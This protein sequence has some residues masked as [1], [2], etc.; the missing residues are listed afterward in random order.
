MINKKIIKLL[1]ENTKKFT[2]PLINLIIEE[3]GKKP[4]LILIACLLSLRAKDTTTIHVCRGL[5]SRALTPEAMFK[6]SHNELEKIIYKSGFYK[7]KASTIHEVS[8]VILEKFD[9]KVPQN[10]DQL[11]SIKGVGA[12]TANLVM[13]MAFGVPA[14]CVDTHV[15]RISNRLGIIKTE[16]PEQTQVELEKMLDKKDWIKWNKLMVMW[17]QNVCL[18]TSPKCCSCAIRMRCKFFVTIRK[19]S[20]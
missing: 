12:K 5:F 15:H 6:I 17:G 16:T 13:G 20:N 2:P 14:I 18:P 1:E 19:K 7:N 8:R 3:Y 4:Y 9:G 11:V 10:Y